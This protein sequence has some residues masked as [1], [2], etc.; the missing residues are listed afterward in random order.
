MN[1]IWCPAP[2]PRSPSTTAASCCDG[3][4]EGLRLKKGC[5][6]FLDE[7]LDRLYEAAIAIDLDI[8]LDRAALTKALYGT[9]A[10]NGMEDDAHVR[11]MVTRG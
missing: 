2:T 8:G 5:L 11:L 1:G 7:H 9:V 4:W 3:I 6:V 10:A